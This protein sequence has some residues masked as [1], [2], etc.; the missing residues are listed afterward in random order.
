VHQGASFEPD[1]DDN[2]RARDCRPVAS[3][4]DRRG[5]RR[6]ITG[7]A[8]AGAEAANTEEEPMVVATAARGALPASSDKLWVADFVAGEAIAA[9]ACAVVCNGGSSAVQQALARGAPVVGIASNMDQ[10]LNMHYVERFGAGILV[11]ADRAT[12]SAIQG[13]AR[14]VI[15]DAKLRARA[16]TVATC[17]AAA[18]VESLF[19][20]ALQE[21]LVGDPQ[22]I[23]NEVFSSP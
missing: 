12:P 8:V 1:G 10:F 11:R 6:I 7:A 2:H 13:A 9:K 5:A 23:R 22:K 17:S 16:Q 4:C 19:S 21:F 18:P 14:R 20:K 3:E 15:A